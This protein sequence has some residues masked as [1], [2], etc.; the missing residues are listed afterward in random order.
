MPPKRRA[1]VTTADAAA[2]PSR[3]AARRSTRQSKEEVIEPVT[4]IK[5]DTAVV[6][7]TKVRTT[8]SPRAKSL[9]SKPRT[10]R[11]SREARNARH[12]STATFYRCLGLED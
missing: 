3:K 10:Q 8:R 1:T 2:L 4:T 9:L 6:E 12:P 11:G 5:P 7:K